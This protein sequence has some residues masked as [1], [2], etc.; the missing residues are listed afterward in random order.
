MTQIS[1]PNTWEDL[2]VSLKDFMAHVSVICAMEHVTARHAELHCLL[3]TILHH[4]T[5]M[6]FLLLTT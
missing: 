1:L 6:L 3:I 2:F 5:T 4:P